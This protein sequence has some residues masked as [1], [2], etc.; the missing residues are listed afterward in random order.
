MSRN[1]RKILHN[2]RDRAQRRARNAG[3]WNKKKAVS[4]LESFRPLNAKNCAMRRKLYAGATEVASRVKARE[5]GHGEVGLVK[6]REKGHCEETPYGKVRW[7]G[8]I[9]M[10]FKAKEDC[11]SDRRLLL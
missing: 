11:G 4:L 6:E 1:Q 10:R 9:E 5:R 2:S 3:Q 7:V 8:D